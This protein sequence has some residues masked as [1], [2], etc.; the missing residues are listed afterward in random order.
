MFRVVH[1]IKCFSLPRERGFS[2]FDTLGE[3]TVFMNRTYDATHI[4]VQVCGACL[5]QYNGNDLACHNDSHWNKV[6]VRG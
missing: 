5:G 2:Y 1:S 3:A 6:E 4:E